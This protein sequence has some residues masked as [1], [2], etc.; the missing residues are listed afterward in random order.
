MFLCFVEERQVNFKTS[1]KKKN[2]FSTIFEIQFHNEHKKNHVFNLTEILQMYTV[3]CRILYDW[4]MNS[5]HWTLCKFVDLSAVFWLVF[6]G[7]ILLLLI[8]FYFNNCFSHITW[9]TNANNHFYPIRWSS[10]YCVMSFLLVCMCKYRC[11]FILPQYAVWVEWI[12]VLWPSQRQIFNFYLN[13]KILLWATATQKKD[14]KKNYMC[15]STH[16]SHKL[17]EAWG[18]YIFNFVDDV[19]F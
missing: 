14:M 10:M 13:S 8:S 12:C 6:F 11:L 7:S 16:N 1:N 5:V 2:S 15:I 19:L 4:L 9:H 17:C 3:Q 18:K